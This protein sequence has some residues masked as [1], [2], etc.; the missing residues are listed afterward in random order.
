[1]SDHTKREQEWKAEQERL[2]NG[3]KPQPPYRPDI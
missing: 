3:I 1:M 2:L